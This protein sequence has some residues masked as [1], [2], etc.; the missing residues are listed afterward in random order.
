MKKIVTLTAQKGNPF[1]VKVTGL[2]IQ[3]LKRPDGKGGNEHYSYTRNIADV[4]SIYNDVFKTQLTFNE[5]QKGGPALTPFDKVKVPARL[6]QGHR[7]GG[8]TPTR[9]DVEDRKWV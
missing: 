6:G 2:A 7:D 1:F 9:A 3:F 4:L 5:S 8:Q